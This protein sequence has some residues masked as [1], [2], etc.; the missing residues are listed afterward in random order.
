M[1]PDIDD[2]KFLDMENFASE[3][4]G[5]KKEITSHGDETEGED[6]MV[7]EIIRVIQEEIKRRKGMVKKDSLEN[8]VKFLAYVNLINSI[9]ANDFENGDDDDDDDDDDFL[10][11]DEDEDNE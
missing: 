8:D 6:A 4:E 10:I 7:L 11:D 2:L 1:I 5:L 3:L 9:L